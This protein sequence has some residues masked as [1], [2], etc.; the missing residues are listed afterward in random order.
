MKFL[1]FLRLNQG[2]TQNQLA[3]HLGTNRNEISKLENGRY[4]TVPASIEGGLIS[5]FGEEW[6]FGSLMMEAPAPS[7]PPL[8]AKRR[9]SRSKS[10][11]GEKRAAA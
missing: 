1:K 5:T 3:L 4:A 2:M 8:P 11:Q 6:T 10:T 9:R 7:A